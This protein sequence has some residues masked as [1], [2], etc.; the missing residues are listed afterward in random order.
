M[1][2]HVLDELLVSKVS[3][4]SR[5]TYSSVYL[6]ILSVT[7]RCVNYYVPFF[8]FILGNGMDI[9]DEL[10]DRGKTLLLFRFSVWCISIARVAK[11]S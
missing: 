7:C 11:S 6:S 3:L 2:M 1:Y 5:S 9:Y 8:T 10:H 4:M